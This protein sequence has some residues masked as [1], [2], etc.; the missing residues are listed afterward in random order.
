MPL[1]LG[2]SGKFGDKLADVIIKDLE[3]NNQINVVY[4]YTKN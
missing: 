3:F 4:Y 2:S 1:Y